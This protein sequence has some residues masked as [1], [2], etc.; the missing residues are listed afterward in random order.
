MPLGTDLYRDSSLEKRM[1]H[2][3]YVLAYGID[4][5]G[6]ENNFN[7]LNAPNVKSR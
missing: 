2:F 1:K 3:Q 4:K 7:S 6:T 5:N